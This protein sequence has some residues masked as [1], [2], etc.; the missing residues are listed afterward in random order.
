MNPTNPLNGITQIEQ[1]NEDLWLGSKRTRHTIRVSKETKRRF[2]QFQAG[3]SKIRGKNQD[4]E[5]TMKHL[6]EIE[7]DFNVFVGK[8]SC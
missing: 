5:A 2:D 6:L 4:Q 8:R 3:F 1:D 7:E